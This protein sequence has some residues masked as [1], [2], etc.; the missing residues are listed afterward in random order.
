MS[1]NQHKPSGGICPKCHIRIHWL[2]FTEDRTIV[3]EYRAGIHYEVDSWPVSEDG[4][5]YEC[6]EC[7]SELY[8]DER[9]ASA[10][11]RRKC[12]VSR[13]RRGNWQG[14]KSS[15]FDEK[16]PEVNAS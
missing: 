15:L 1:M 13:V 12:K 8:R 14:E 16:I 5:T 7:G 9:E 4:K 11:L 6:P 2:V 3:G 10:F